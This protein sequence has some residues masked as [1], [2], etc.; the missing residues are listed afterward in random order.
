MT[1]SVIDSSI[2]Y[3]AVAAAVVFAVRN[4]GDDSRKSFIQ[5]LQNQASNQ[6]R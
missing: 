1:C 6:L 3:F 2:C 4:D 5:G